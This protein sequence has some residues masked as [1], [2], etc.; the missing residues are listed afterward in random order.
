LRENAIRFIRQPKSG[1]DPGVAAIFPAKAG[2]QIFCLW[3]AVAMKHFWVMALA[4]FCLLPAAHAQ[5]EADERYVTIYNLIQQGDNLASSGQATDALSTYTDAQGRL[6]KFQKLYPGW[7]P[8]IVNYRLD[9]LSKKIGQLQI[10]LAPKQVPARTPVNTAD[11][12]AAQLQAQLA[13]EQQQV[14]SAQAENQA[15]QAKLKE[16]LATQPAVIDASELTAAQDQIRELMKENDLMKA[17]PSGPGEPVVVTD[18]NQINAL[19]QQLA[20]ALKKYNDEQARAQTLV[21]EN[22][23]LQRNIA[24]TG[25][26]AQSLDVIS[27][28]NDRLRAQLAELQKASDSA[29]AAGELA[30]KLNDARTQIANLQAATALASLEKAG[31]ENKVRKLSSQLAESAA[32]FDGRVRDLTDQRDDLLKQLG[33][34]NSKNS[35]RQVSDVASQITELNNEVNVLRSRIAVDESKAIPYTPEELALFKQAAPEVEQVQKSITQMPAGTANLVASAQR[36]FSNHEFDQ[37]EA[38]YQQ[39]LDRDQ[40]NGLALANL[41]T[42]ELQEDKFDLAEKHIK[43]ALAQSPEDSYNL[44]TLGYLKFRQEKYDEALDA[45]S[46]AVRVD[47]NNPET[48]NYLGVTLSHKG[49]RMQAETALRRALQLDPNYAPAHNNIAVIYLSQTPPLPQLARW[50]YQKALDAGQ[51]RNPELEKMLADKGAPMSQ[52]SPNPQ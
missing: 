24:K 5:Q 34:A 51:P 40:N 8:S 32:N 31:L 9:D 28:E 16:A 26:D 21:Q 33:A 20:D 43:A 7:D 12:V 49:L 36:H 4:V 3:H 22:T 1:H 42:I 39:I 25:T 2:C 29:A 45:L 6:A 27:S 10:Q 23:S 11:A 50:H 18:T 38:D 13:A 35:H 37:A 19:R 15:L 41:A 14:Q 30:A 48:Q 44:S 47:P 52:G 46:H 17:T